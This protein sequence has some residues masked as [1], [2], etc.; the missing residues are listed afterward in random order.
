MFAIPA[1][2]SSKSPRNSINDPENAA[3]NAGNPGSARLLIA[4]FGLRI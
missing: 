2:T 3:M 4:E 1:A